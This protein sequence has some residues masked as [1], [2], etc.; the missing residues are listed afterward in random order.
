[1]LKARLSYVSG[2]VAMAAAFATYLGPYSH[3]FRRLMLTVKWPHC[4]RE[5]GVPLVFDSVDSLRG[6]SL[7]S[8]IAESCFGTHL[9]KKDAAS[10]NV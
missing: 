6:K 9:K 7:C 10:A 1:M 2:A 4:L 5:R 3:S 8:V